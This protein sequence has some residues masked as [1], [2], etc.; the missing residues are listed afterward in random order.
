MATLFKDGEV[1]EDPWISVD[2][3]QP[4]PEGA[5]VIVSLDVFLSE[6]HAL[7]TRN[8]GRLGVHLEAGDTLDPIIEH[9]GKLDVVSLDFPSFAD[10][11]S[12][13]KARWLR[14][15]HFYAGEVRAVGDIRIDQVGHLQRCGFNTL[16]VSH[17]QTIESLIK[18]KDPRLKLYYQPAAGDTEK[19]AG[20]RSWTRRA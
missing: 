8:A 20:E 14:D 10:G 16:L 15:Q 6:Q 17:Q 12:F 5:D 18:V 2:G 3:E 19:R 9:L 1:A 7:L 4:V 11:R 13:S